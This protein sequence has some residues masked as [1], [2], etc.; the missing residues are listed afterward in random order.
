MEEILLKEVNGIIRK[1][2][3]ES[4]DVN[5]NNLIT[6]R[7]TLLMILQNDGLTDEEL[8]IWAKSM[9]P[10]YTEKHHIEN[11]IIELNSIIDEILNLA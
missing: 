1:Y 11:Q 10:H 4:V 2:Y 9:H 8:L 6:Q 5:L 7:D 3:V